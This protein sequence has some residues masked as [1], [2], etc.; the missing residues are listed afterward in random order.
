[1]LLN[2]NKIRKIS[3]NFGSSLIDKYNDKFKKFFYKLKEQIESNQKLSSIFSDFIKTRKIT[4]EQYI[5]IKTIVYD[6]FKL[7]G[8]GSLL[9]LPLPG[10][11][12]LMLFL[13]NQ[14]KRL[15]INLLPTKFNENNSNTIYEYKKWKRKN[16]TIRGISSNI[17]EYNNSG[18]QFGDGLYTAHLSN[19]ELA[20]KYGNVYFVL[21]A[22]PKNPK[23]VNSINDAEIWI[24]RNLYH[25]NGYKG[26]RDFFSHTN[27]KDE[28]LKLGYDGLEIKGR[29]IVNYSPSDDIKY[30]KND[31]ELLDYFIRNVLTQ[32]NEFY[33]GSDNVKNVKFKLN[34]QLTLS[35]GKSYNSNDEWIIDKAIDDNHYCTN[36]NTNEKEN[37]HTDIIL[38][39]TKM[40]EEDLQKFK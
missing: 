22:R 9:L 21:G 19:R 4:K 2:I 1:M 20:K 35:N 29:E 31:E 12:L 10:S 27:I 8:L 13:I 7:V 36:L 26:I 6:D 40:S 17:G 25:A 15:G 24:Q 37:F 16:V 33:L 3:E 38:S 32:V 5:E 30:F 11:T 14:S 18:A 23:I 34:K 28:M 39:Y